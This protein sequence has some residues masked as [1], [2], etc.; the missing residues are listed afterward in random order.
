[1]ADNNPISNNKPDTSTAMTQLIDQV[2]EAIP[3]DT[4]A[5][6][7][8]AGPCT[9]C[10]KKL[11]EYLDSELEDWEY[12]L[13]SAEAPSLGDVRKLGKTSQKIYNVL[14]KN[15]LIVDAAS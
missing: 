9:G 6:K 14:K 8:C 11:M 4:P 2:R 5:E 10:P 15:N 1:M 7:L 13:D 12:K 3:F